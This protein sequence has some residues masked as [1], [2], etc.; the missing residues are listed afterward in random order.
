MGIQKEF[1]VFCF[2]Q[3]SRSLSL[4]LSLSARSHLSLSPL[5]LSRG[6]AGG[7]AGSRFWYPLLTGFAGR[8]LEPPEVSRVPSDCSVP[9]GW[10]VS[11][12]GSSVGPGTALR[13]SWSGTRRGGGRA[14]F[15]WAHRADQ[16]SLSRRFTATPTHS[17]SL[18][19]SLSVS[20]SPS[21]SLSLSLALS[22]SLALCLS[23]SLTLSLSVSR[24]LSL[25]SLSLSL[26]LSHSLALCLSLS[27]RQHC[28]SLYLSVSRPLCL[29]LSLS[30]SSIPDHQPVLSGRPPDSSKWTSFETG[31]ACVSNSY[32]NIQY[33]WF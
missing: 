18:T 26:A 28:L 6:H 10:P 3:Y 30:L 15:P 9:A 8:S 14:G 7:P 24:S 1:F 33:F 21:L 27:V 20:R 25:A 23:L 29:S 19:L 22:H 4:S 11:L 17:R 16:P 12:G 32:S 13:R 2:I 5:C 31:S